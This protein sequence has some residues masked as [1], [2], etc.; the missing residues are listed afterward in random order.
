MQTVTTIG[1]DLA[2]L[3]LQVRGVDG[4]GVVLITR[5]LRRSQV[6]DFFRRLCHVVEPRARKASVWDNFKPQ[7]PHATRSSP[8][9]EDSVGMGGCEVAPDVE[10]VVDGRVS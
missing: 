8:W 4:E 2:K 10:D 7:R 1:L 5:A 3:V 9:L 6:L